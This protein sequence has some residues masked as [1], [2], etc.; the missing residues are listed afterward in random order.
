VLKADEDQ[1]VYYSSGLGESV[2]GCAGR[3]PA[4]A[5]PQGAADNRHCPA[6]QHGRVGRVPAQNCLDD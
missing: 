3:S 1:F 4:S 2:H 5:E 6:C